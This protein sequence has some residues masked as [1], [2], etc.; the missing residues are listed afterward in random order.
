MDSEIWQ[1]IRNGDS[2]AMRTL[3][4]GCYQ[5]L[6]AFGFRMLPDKDKIKDCLHEIFSEIWQKRENI[7]D[8]KHIKAYLKA[9]VRNKLLKEIKQDQLIERLPNNLDLVD[10]TVHSYEQ[11][12]IE[13]ENESDAK[14]R[15]WN[16]LD[17][18]T[19]MQREVVKLKFFD[20]LNY[21]A[22]AIL[23][24]LKPR[25]VYNHMYAAIG[26]LRKALK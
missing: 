8:V 2:S 15:L 22:I 9:C 10:L 18:L 3:Y 4:Q 6:Y 5:D 13:S 17:L 11:L 12:L 14:K 16:A 23:L 26:V 20:E 19:P 1:N 24:K 21:E 25:T 7:G